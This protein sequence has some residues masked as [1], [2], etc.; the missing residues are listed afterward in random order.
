MEK[1]LLDLTITA[2]NLVA[3]AVNIASV[4]LY[5]YY[6]EQEDERPTWVS[7][8]YTYTKT[9]NGLYVVLVAIHFLIL[10]NPFK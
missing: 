1:L 3:I 6:S 10:Y 2:I 7:V 8:L 9:M 5:M 4:V